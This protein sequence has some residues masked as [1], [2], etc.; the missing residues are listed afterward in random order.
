[1]GLKP[2]TRPV[3]WN[4]AV[5]SGEQMSNDYFSLSSWRAKEP[6]GGIEHQPDFFQG[7]EATNVFRL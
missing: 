1:M 3:F 7:N 2:P 4:W 5:F 6:E